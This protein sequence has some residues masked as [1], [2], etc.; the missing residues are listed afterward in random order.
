[1]PEQFAEG[2][3]PFVYLFSESATRAL[4]SVPRGHDKAFAALCAERGVPF[5]LIGVT[6]P[7]GGALEVHGQFRI[8]LDELRA[9]HTETLPRLFGGSAAVEV[10]AP[11]AGVA[12]AVEAVPLPGEPSEPVDPAEV[13]SEPIA[14]SGP[15]PETGAVEPIGSEQSAEASESDSGVT[16][17]SPDER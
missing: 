13:V 4:V 15:S 16:E 10:P 9:A 5:E 17:P 1:V 8:G 12:G 6:D 14:S 3:M 2:S 7:S 11:A